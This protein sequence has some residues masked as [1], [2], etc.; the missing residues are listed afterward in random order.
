MNI[1]GVEVPACMLIGLMLLLLPVAAAGA[2]FQQFGEVRVYYTSLRSTLI[3]AKVAAQYDIV[4]VVNQAVTNIAVK[5]NNRAVKARISGFSTNLMNQASKLK[6]AEV[7]EQ[8]AIY[9]LASSP[10]GSNE[11]IV[12]SVKIEIEGRNSPIVLEFKQ[13][14]Y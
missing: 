1:H 3:P 14:Y 12:Y 6:F 7:R 13:S 8:S 10:V 2:Q 11:T 5:Q 9:Y 4:R